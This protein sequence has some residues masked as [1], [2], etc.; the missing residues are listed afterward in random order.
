MSLISSTYH[1]TWIH[2]IY[3]L[4]CCA[5]VLISQV[6]QLKQL[7]LQKALNFNQELWR[8]HK[9]QYEM[10]KEN[11]DIINRKCHDLKH[12][13]TALKHIDDVEK[14]KKAIDSMERSINIYDSI[15]E[16]GN[17]ILD[18]VITEKNLICDANHIDMQCI[19]D[20]KLLDFIDA[21]DIYT[22]FGNV[23]DN[24]KKLAYKKTVTA[25]LIS[26]EYRW[27]P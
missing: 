18:T 3:A 10:S 4:F 15:L 16:T 12:Q 2:A 8:K 7:S 24:A 17:D 11:I 21:I 20:G 9:A 19:L 13:A 22:L 1:F 5:F 25:P 23:L 6:N 27:L 26:H 14:Q